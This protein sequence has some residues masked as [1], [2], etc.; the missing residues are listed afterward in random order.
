[1]GK[2]TGGITIIDTLKNLETLVKAADGALAQEIMALD[3]A[4]VTPLADYFV[5]MH[6]K[7]DRQLSAIVDE[8][9]DTA[10]KNEMDVKSVEGKNGGRWVLID[11]NDIIVHVFH[12]TERANYNLEKIWQ[13]APLVDTTAWVID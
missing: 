10:H 3:V 4:K 12:Y 5:I 11:L 8:I 6:A 7:N 13:D 1:M 9:V 2:K